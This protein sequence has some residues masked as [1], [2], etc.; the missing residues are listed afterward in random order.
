[1]EKDETH[2][3]LLFQQY[4]NQLELISQQV[5]LLDNLI[6]EYERAK[7]TLE[8]ISNAEKDK[9]I[10]IPI[11]GNTFVFGT[12]KDKTKVITGIGGNISIEKKINNTLTSLQ[13]KM[14]EFRKEEEKLVKMAQDIQGKSEM[15]SQ[16]IREQRGEK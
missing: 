6:L 3:I 9:E 15:L 10:L 16:K 2:D 13:H 5:T 1:M 4:Q 11:G 14:E 12:L 7:E 8:E